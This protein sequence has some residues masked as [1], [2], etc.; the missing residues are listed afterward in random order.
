MK[1]L[2]DIAALAAT[3]TL[4]DVRPEIRAMK[5]GMMVKVQRSKI[6]YYA[7]LYQAGPLNEQIGDHNAPPEEIRYLAELAVALGD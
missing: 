7:T 2:N 3:L 1:L 4:A 6:N 5:W